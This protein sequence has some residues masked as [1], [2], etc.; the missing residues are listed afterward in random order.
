MN[1]PLNLTEEELD[2]LAE[3][4]DEEL[5]EAAREAF[6]AVDVKAIWF[7]ARRQSLTDLGLL[8]CDESPATDVAMGF[9]SNTGPRALLEDW[10]LLR[11]I[12]ALNLAV[13][14]TQNGLYDEYLGIVRA[15]LA[16]ASPHGTEAG[17]LTQERLAT[18]EWGK[19]LL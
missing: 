3:A 16:E 11:T 19:F 15:V 2:L 9:Y 12:R 13:I 6:E 17:R 4:S 10:D 14:L 8:L 18:M 1:D 7:A 5:E